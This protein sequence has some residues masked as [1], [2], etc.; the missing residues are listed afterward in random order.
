MLGFPNRIRYCDYK[1]RYMI[2]GAE[3]GAS[4]SDNKVAV[5]ALMAKVEFPP[6]KFRCGHT[7]VF[8]RAGALAAL[9]EARDGI[10]LKL[11]RW[12]QGQCYGIIRRKVYQKKEDQR[13]LMKVCQRN[14]RKYMQLRTWGWFVIIQKTKPL[15]GQPNPEEELRKLEE[16]AN[17]SYG[18]YQEALQVTK[19]LQEDGEK[20]KDEIKA[21]TKQ[22]EAE[23]G[24]LSQYTERQAA[25]SAKKVGLESELASAQQTL[26]NEEQARQAMTA[27]KKSMEAEVTV[28]KKDMEDLELAKKIRTR[29]N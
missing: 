2:L 7:M 27:D 28:V 17:A 12:M 21:L 22:L 26:A 4:S 18:K 25:A 1:M 16:A 20:V 24:N 10:V 13:E 8:F 6:E 23:Q 15:V 19:E 3:H 5:N 9:E 14:F 29:E 11:V